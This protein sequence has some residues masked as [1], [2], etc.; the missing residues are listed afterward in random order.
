MLS[1]SL[2]PVVCISHGASNDV[3]EFSIKLFY[4][5]EMP[6]KSF[7]PSEK[8][9][10]D[11]KLTDYFF[12]MTQQFN[13]VADKLIPIRLTATMIRKFCKIIEQSS[14]KLSKADV[15]PQ[16]ITA[17]SPIFE[18]ILISFSLYLSFEHY[19]N[20]KILLCVENFNFISHVVRRF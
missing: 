18:S 8:N 12:R 7:S 14:R 5:N 20:R 15:K 9:R 4:V 19:K 6:R 10:W 2:W 16:Q 1:Q 13:C 17:M 3:R 11:N